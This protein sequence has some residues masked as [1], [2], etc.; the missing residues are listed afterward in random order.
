MTTG[1]DFLYFYKKTDDDFELRHSL[2]SIEL[3]VPW[4]RKVWIYG[5]RPDFLTTDTSVVE[6]VPDSFATAV[7]GI[8]PPVRNT[9]Q[10][11]FLSSLIP[12]LTPEFIWCSDDHFLLKDYELDDAKNVR[13]LE[14]LSTVNR[15][16]KPGV[17][18]AQLWHTYDALLRLGYPAYNFETHTPIY[19]TKGRVL[20]AYCALK[21]LVTFD[22]WYGLM[23][24]T[25][26]L[27]HASK[28][29][30]MPVHSIAE[31]G[32]RVGWHGELKLSYEEV[33][34]E[35]AGKTYLYLGEGALNDVTRQFL[36]TRF[37]KP[38][39]FEADEP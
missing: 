24:A 38:S 34:R 8:R 13:Y 21:D 30:G 29:D 36:A 17:W 7:L 31:E 22:R 33:V 28:E 20:H 19:F 37:P 4:A 5:D 15:P 12:E 35:T 6:Q 39:R 26:I 2:R 16:T 1:I 23:G 10:M 27:N 32:S 3:H 14:D 18:K 9:F 11:L 25:A